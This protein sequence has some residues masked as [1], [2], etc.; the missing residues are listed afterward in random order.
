MTG[1]AATSSVTSVVDPDTG[2][3][4]RRFYRARRSLSA[5]SMVVCH[6]ARV[7]PRM[8]DVVNDLVHA[9]TVFHLRKNERAAAAH[10]PTVTF[11]HFQ[12]G[13][14]HFG[15]IRFVDY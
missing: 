10:G 7:L 12:V 5:T 4:A 8:Q 6:A 11:H 1:D 2:L 15:Q 13:A 14:H 3:H 9:D